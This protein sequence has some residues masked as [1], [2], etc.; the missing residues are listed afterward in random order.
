MKWRALS[1]LAGLLLALTVVVVAY[2]H[3]ASI[4]YTT[5]VTVTLRAAYDSGEP[6]AGG[7]VTVYAPEDPTTPWLTGVCDEEGR[8]R[9]TP[10]PAMPGTWD[11]QVRQAGHGDIVHIPIAEGLA[12]SSGGGYSTG[13]VLLM[14]ASVIW[15]FVGTALFFSRR[16][17]LNNSG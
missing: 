7:Q 3:G 15:G 9:F 4:E 2:A 8:F 1:A 13:Q 12:S 10:D 17:A 11:V 5:E 6:M 14:V 16:S